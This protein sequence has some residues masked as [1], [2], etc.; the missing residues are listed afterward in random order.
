MKHNTPNISGLGT[1]RVAFASIALA[2]A[3]LAGCRDE[4]TNDPPR[5]FIPDMDDTPKFKPQSETAL[6]ADGRTMRAH[7]AHTVAFG[8]SWR[9]DDSARAKYLMGS[10]EQFTGVD[11]KAPPLPENAPLG[12]AGAKGVQY[13]A[14]MP[15]GVIDSAILEAADRGQ[16][17]DRPA[18]M[19]AMLARGEERFNIFCAACHGYDAEGGNN[20]QFT[21]GLVGRRWGAPV[22]SFHDAKYQ[23]RSLQT[24]QDGYIFHVIRNGVPDADPAK[25]LKMPSYKDRVSVSDAW[26]IVYYV[27]VL[28]ASRQ[29]DL[30]NVPPDLRSKL[31][32]TRPDLSSAAPVSGADQPKEARP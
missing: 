31:E 18:A 19:Q 20:A 10:V 21:G 29:A 12:A 14:Y 16:K 15:P 13:V 27:R 2:T 4:R 5:Q 28:Q 32:S 9:P 17:L 26:A 8:D 3:V 11:P 25:P 1:K 24:G 30:K 23:D 6:F 22:P 7:A